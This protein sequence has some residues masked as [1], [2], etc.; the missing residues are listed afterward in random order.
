MPL[1][2]APA[3]PLA[4]SNHALRHS[5]GFERYA[6]TLVRG[7]HERG[8]RPVFI[9]RSFDTSL[10]E[11][12]WVEPIRLGMF[13]VPS[14]LRD[15]FFDWRIGRVKRRLGLGPLIAC[16]PTRW[17]DIAVCGGTHPGYLHAM[18]KPMRGSDRR[19]IALEHA[20]FGSA[21]V[22]VAH[23]ALMQREL[24]QHH[25]IDATRIV[26]LYPPT[27]TE[28]FSPVDPARRDALRAQLG[29]PTN[30][31]VFLLASTGHERKGLGVLAEFFGRTGL[32]AT[33]VVAGRAPDAASPNVR[34]LGYR[35]DIE[36]VYRAVDFTIMA[37]AYEPFGLVGIE[38]VL[39]GTPVLLASGVGCGEVLEPPA[40]IRYDSAA[41]DGLADAV[42]E[43]LARWQA[44]AHRLHEP[45]LRMGYDPRVALHVDALLVLA[46]NTQLSAVR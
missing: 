15:L 39:C 10:P 40:C 11:Y 21:R 19:K 7:L 13:G 24:M 9:A 2:A 23:S 38:S 44:G 36:N 32:P 12:A 22:V 3:E 43:A 6:M 34:Y 29:L 4:I 8:V 37:S 5:G 35:T 20:F 28:R 16:N 27:D 31:A 33:L 14:K 25:G 1:S 30:R 42:R 45:A 17:A 41:A 18:G 46:R 26:L